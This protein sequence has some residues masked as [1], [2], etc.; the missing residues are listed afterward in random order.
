[1]PV[2]YGEGMEL[3]HLRYFIAV[4]ETENVTRAAALLHVAQPAL[5][6][7][8]R[9]LERELSVDL[10]DHAVRSIRLNDAGRHFLEEARETVARFEHA[11]RSVRAFSGA[12]HRE[13][14]LGYAPSLI[15]KILPR[16]LREFQKAR[17]HVRVSLHDVSTEAMLAGLR[18]NKLHV[19]M[20]VKPSKPALDSLIYEEIMRF[21]P[22][23]A[24]PLSHPFATAHV[25]TPRSLANE[26]LISYSQ[27]DY[28]EHL[29]WLKQVFKGTVF[30]RIA[31]ECDSSSSL[32]AAVELGDGVAVVQEG[33]EALA[34]DRLAVRLL[35]S[36][37]DASFSFGIARRK[38]DASQITQTFIRLVLATRSGPDNTS[39]PT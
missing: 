37:E 20:L 2:R 27:V 39:K 3:R 33:F 16:I 35:K 38:D 15:T 26:R 19:A 23:V 24:I 5:S 34:G 21:S 8:I 25:L 1:M 10:F 6:R 13:L 30:P 32:I 36:A 17:P 14:H 28:P 22:C 29:T 12:P 11:V 7:Q 4:A 18:E 9:D 31:V